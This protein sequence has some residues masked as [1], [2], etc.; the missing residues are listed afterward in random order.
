[1][2]IPSSP[3]FA[4]LHSLSN[5]PRSPLGMTPTP[6]S[7]LARVTALCGGPQIWIKRDDCTGLATGG[8]KT[9]KLEFL[10]GQARAMGC[11]TLISQG[12]LQSNHARQV[13]A[14]GAV[15][16]M[17]VHL[18]L[19]D[20]VPDRSANYAKVGNIQ[21]CRLLGA[22]V[23]CIVGDANADE[24]CAALAQQLRRDGSR[25]YVIPMGGSNGMG[26]LGYAAAFA[27]LAQQMQ[28][29]NAPLDA[30]VLASGSGGTQAGLMLGG[31][32]QGWQGRIHGVS[33]G[34]TKEVLSARVNYAL[35]DACELLGLPA[36]AAASVELITEMGFKGP[37][38]G[39]PDAATFKALELAAREE[40]ILLDPVYSAKGFAGLLQACAT[41]GALHGLS[42]VVFL[43]TGGVAAMSAYPEAGEVL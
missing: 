39:V 36:D 17:K 8:N 3:A 4:A 42:N 19:S 32:L 35:V 13:A 34:P 9:R 30:V 20:A 28:Q 1:M 14:A 10:L 40:G 27:E 41:G 15:A 37:H 11:D 26:A 25:P 33:V 5:L 22:Q 24:V 31:W 38:Y 23:Q 6:L 2:S 16:G 12:A 18:V 21:L 29:L 43:H 7:L